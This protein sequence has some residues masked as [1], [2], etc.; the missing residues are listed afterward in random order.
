VDTHTAVAQVPVATDTLGRRIVARRHRTVP[1]PDA[2][3][4]T[5]NM[6]SSAA[7]IFRASDLTW[8]RSLVS[9]FVAAIWDGNGRIT[10]LEN[11]GGVVRS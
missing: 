4:S 5:T 6:C 9:D 10:A 1:W 3:R 7:A 2:Y 11:V 8:Y